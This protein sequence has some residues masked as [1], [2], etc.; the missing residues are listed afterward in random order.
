MRRT[1]AVGSLVRSLRLLAGVRSEAE[2]VVLPELPEAAVRRWAG[3]GVVP[4]V[5]EQAH[6][7]RVD[8][9]RAR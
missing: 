4:E 1:I 2:G 8:G 3:D 6:G 7:G 9:G 5:V